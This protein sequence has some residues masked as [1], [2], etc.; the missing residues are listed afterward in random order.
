VVVE[1]QRDLVGEL[2]GCVDGAVGRQEGQGH[3]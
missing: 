3:D 1:G 2:A